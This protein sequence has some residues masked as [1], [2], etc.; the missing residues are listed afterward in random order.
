MTKVAGTFGAPMRRA[1]FGSHCT[2]KDGAS[3]GHDPGEA[4]ETRADRAVGDARA[5]AP[6]SA[7]GDNHAARRR[8]IR[9]RFAAALRTAALAAALAA[10]AVAAAGDAA[11]ARI[12]NTWR[13]MFELQPGVT[14]T[15]TLTY[16]APGRSPAIPPWQG[17]MPGGPEAGGGPG[18]GRRTDYVTGEL[19]L[20]RSGGVNDEVRFW[21]VVDGVRVNG[22]APADPQ[23][24]AGAV[25]VAALTSPEPISTEGVRLL[26]TVFQWTRWRDLFA[27]ATFRNGTVWEVLQ[28]P[29]LRFT[30]R[31]YG[32]SGSYRGEVVRGRDTV[33]EIAID[34]SRPLPLEIVAFEGRHRYRAELVQEPVWGP[35]R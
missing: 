22:T 6:A 26:A 25:L 35:R 2:T 7:A 12:G 13:A 15:Y 32:F 4:H 23:A 1:V 19:H 24:V 18:A 20:W 8:S 31:Q 11:A 16:Q 5:G 10:A 9:R 30:A 29:T 27:Q 28:H 17:N 21:F 3:G 34:V 33:L 14:Y